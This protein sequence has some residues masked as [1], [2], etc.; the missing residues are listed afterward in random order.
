[1][2]RQS[3]KC[4]DNYKGSPTSS[5]N[6]M[7]FGPQMALNSTCIIHTLRKLCILLYCHAS[8]TQI[9]KQNSTKLCQMADGKQLGSSPRKQLGTKKLLH[10]FGFS[11]TSTLNG[12]YL[13]KET[14]HRQSGKGVGKCEGSCTLSRIFLPTFTILFRPN[15]SHTL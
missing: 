10:L 7:N 14:W 4:V 12:E 6:V 5:Q 1:M 2:F 3:V 9:S 8:Q 13:L 11:T 15:P